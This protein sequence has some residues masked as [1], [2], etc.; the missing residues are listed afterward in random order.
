MN[1][2][3]IDSALEALTNIL[4]GCGVALIAQLIWFPMLGKE[5]TLSENLLTTAFF[6]IVSFARSY[7]I[8]R[9]FDGKP[10]Y[11]SI[12]KKCKS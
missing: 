4:I 3:K 11:A 1:Q 9:A 6:T 5:F 7:I 10:V 12:F 8:R 2:S